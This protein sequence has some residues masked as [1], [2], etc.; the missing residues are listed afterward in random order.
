[1]LILRVIRLTFRVG[2]GSVIRGYSVIR[3]EGDVVH[4]E[5]GQGFLKFILVMGHQS[6]P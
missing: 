4:P 2:G 3:R 5:R 1:M 6:K